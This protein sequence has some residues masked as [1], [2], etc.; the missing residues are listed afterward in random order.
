MEKRE[1]GAAVGVAS[2]LSQGK[3]VTTDTRY[4]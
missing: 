2:Q 1:A 4:W 3:R